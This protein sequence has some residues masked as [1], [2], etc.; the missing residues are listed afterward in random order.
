MTPEPLY[1]FRRQGRSW[2][3][4][5]A[6]GAAW[7]FLF[8]AWLVFDAAPVLVGGLFALT[9]PAAWDLYSG[10]AAG[11]DLTA[12]SLT[13]FSGP[14]DMT[15][16]RNEIDHIRLVTRLDLTVRAA[17]VLKNGNKL[18]LPAESTPP[19]DAF[20]AALGAAGLRSER[21]HFTFL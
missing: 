12:D 20:E 19:S 16:P 10:R 9:L 21:H 11:A 13:W 7:L 5:C 18:R 17:V 8:V 6:L 15:V 1:R 2:A 4:L 3:T 14:H